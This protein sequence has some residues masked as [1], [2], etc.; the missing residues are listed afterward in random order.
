MP[1]EGQFNVTVLWAHEIRVASKALQ[2]L[3]DVAKSGSP[4]SEAENKRL[5]H[6][7]VNACIVAIGGIK[8]GTNLTIC[9]GP[10]VEFAKEPK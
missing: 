1:S 3:L 10:M 4:I 2:N 8:A 9:E 7:A 6:T 5:V